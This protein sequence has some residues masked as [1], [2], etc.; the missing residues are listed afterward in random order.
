MEAASCNPGHGFYGLLRVNRRGMIP[1][2]VLPDGTVM[3]ESAAILIHLGLV[4]TPGLLLPVD[5]GARARVLRGL[6]FITATCYAAISVIDY[7]ERWCEPCDEAIKVQI[8][9]GTRA[10]LHEHW[11]VFADERVRVVRGERVEPKLN[12]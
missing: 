12:V 5:A 10:R 7:P 9:A 11:R 6:V 8:R 2:L 1:T 3:T 4:S